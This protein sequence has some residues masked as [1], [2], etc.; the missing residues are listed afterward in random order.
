MSIRN[1]S[2]SPSTPIAVSGVF[3]RP[4]RVGGAEFMLYGLVE[5]LLQLGESV[6]LFY[7]EGETLDPFFAGRTREACSTG[8]L[9]CRTLRV[10]GNRFVAETTQLMRRSRELQARELILPNYYTPPFRGHL[11]T[12]TA[13]LDLQYLHYPQFFSPQKRLWLRAAHEF[14]LRRAD[15]VSVISDFVRGDLLERYGTRYESR[16]R[17][18]PIGISWDR[19][20]T[21]RKPEALS[22]RAAPFI[23]S[24]AS[25]YS[26]K[27]LATLIRAYARLASVLPHDLV[28]VGQ[29]RANLIGVR[30][31]SIVDL[32]TLSASLGV[33][34]RVVMTGHASDEVVGWCYRNA[35]LFVFPSLFE[36][37]GMPAV[38]ALGFGLPVVTTRCGSLPEVTRGLATLVERPE[39]VE[40]LASTITSTLKR[41]ALSRPSANDV[42]SLRSYYDPARVAR[43]YLEALRN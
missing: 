9:A 37:F 23:L 19:F 18:I 42:E 10:R 16:V 3:L 36:G 11:K 1:A 34:N 14:T 17:T 8:A 29:R 5:G 15:R 40:E 20:A 24:V 2:S 7:P 21:P 27:N 13:I 4:G 43:L 31:G 41:G 22:G 38:E 39:D 33:A 30:D 28:L 32:E 6:T 12:L 25:H 35:D 26:H